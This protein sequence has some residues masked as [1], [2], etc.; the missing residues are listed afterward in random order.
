[1]KKVFYLFVSF[2]DVSNYWACALEHVSYIYANFT[3]L[4]R[5]F[6]YIDRRLIIPALMFGFNGNSLKIFSFLGTKEWVQKYLRYTPDQRA[7]L[8]WDSFRGRWARQ[9]IRHRQ[10]KRRRVHPKQYTTQTVLFRTTPVVFRNNI[11]IKVNDQHC[12]LFYLLEF[13]PVTA[14]QN[15]VSGKYSPIRRT[16]TLAVIFS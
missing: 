4:V 9:R 3:S 12:V 7:L 15:N 16:Q 11:F 6:V 2:C 1:M 13:V 5:E 10:S 14:I 8:V